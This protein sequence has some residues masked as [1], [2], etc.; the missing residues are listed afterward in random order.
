ME[1]GVSIPET[2]G[3]C[4]VS[5]GLFGDKGS[6]GVMRILLTLFRKLNKIALTCCIFWCKE[7]DIEKVEQLVYS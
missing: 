6:S 1:G 5:G 7:T 2:D 3:V 4:S